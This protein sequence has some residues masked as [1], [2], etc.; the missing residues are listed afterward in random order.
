MFLRNFLTPPHP[1]PKNWS[2]P[3]D[4]VSILVG[5]LDVVQRG[6]P[7]GHTYIFDDEEGVGQVWEV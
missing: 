6:D 7:K 1:R 4:I 3:T 5:G 2:A